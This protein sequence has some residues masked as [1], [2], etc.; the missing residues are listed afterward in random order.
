MLVSGY[1]RRPEYRIDLVP[2]RTLVTARSARGVIAASRRTFRL[3]EQDHASVFYFPADDVV[4][5]A[6]TAIDRKTTFCP[7]KGEATYFAPSDQ[8][9]KAIAWTYAE[10]F[11]EVAPIAGYIAFYAELVAVVEG[12]T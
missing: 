1:E 7:F 8:P 5:G 6:L 10:P 2:R 9:G 11:R 3:D 4:S 12:K